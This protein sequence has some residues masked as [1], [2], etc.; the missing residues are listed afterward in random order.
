MKKVFSFS[1]FIL[2]IL[3][4][5]FSSCKNNQ[6]NVPDNDPD[7]DP[8]SRERNVVL[9]EYFT[10]QR[11][12]YCPEGLKY[13]LRN[14]KG[15]EDKVAFVAHHVGFGE[16]DFTIKESVP[17]KFF[18]ASTD[19][20]TYAPAMMLDR[21]YINGKN[22]DEERKDAVIFS[23][24]AFEK[25]DIK[26]M[27]EV[28][29]GASMK[30]TTELDESGST[31]T[32]KVSGKLHDEYPNAKI[33]VYIT[34]DSIKGYEQSG[35]DNWKNYYHRNAIRVSLTGNW[36]EDMGVSK[37]DY[38]KEYTYTIPD[39]IRGKSGVSI[40]TD[41]NKMSVVAFIAEVNDVKTIKG[42]RNNKVLN[43]AVAKIK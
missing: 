4:I 10:G 2:A 9:L 15:M 31:L 39:K 21:T 26:K 18:Y 24:G 1:L 29:A 5:G 35:V 37:G 28:P 34:Q 30:L 7:F 17:L 14:I 19:G 11:C 6:P 3:L 36:G 33:N 12:G 27:L 23:V 13:V 8:D 41:V 32:V 40:K 25:S 22:S 20:S 43:A 38:S 16:D 42:A